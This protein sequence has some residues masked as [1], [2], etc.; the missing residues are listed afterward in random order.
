M[1]SPLEI[2][3]EKYRTELL[4]KN[5]YNTGNSYNS[6]NKNALSDGDDK[7]KGELNG[8]VGSQTD[9]NT[10]I[11]NVSK[12]KFKDKNEYN[13]SNKD[14]LSDGDEFGKGELNGSVG[15]KTDINTRIEIT[16]KNA[17]TPKKS[18]PDFQ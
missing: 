17:Y 8:S 18:Y 4:N 10:R 7:C 1:P 3:S 11:D 2:I 13:S 5:S 15:S 6:I 12:N 9:I 14:A 16:N